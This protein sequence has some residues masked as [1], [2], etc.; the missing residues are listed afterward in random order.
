[1]TLLNEKTP[2]AQIVLDHSEC[3]GVFQR[4]RIDYCCKGELP[5]DEACRQRGADPKAV[6]EELERAVAERREPAGIDPREVPTDVLVS[7]IVRRHHQYLRDALPFL[8][9]L[10]KKVARVHGAHNPNLPEVRD[11]VEELSNLML[12]HLDREE[13]VLFPALEGEGKGREEVIAAELSTMHGDHLEVA[14]VLESLRTAASEFEIPDWACTS[15]TTLYRE[16][17]AVEADIFQ[18][19]HLENHVLMPRFARG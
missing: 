13:Q 2:V 7:H 12:P 3:A 5:L 18:H 1:M 9:P 16:L 10:S 6:L 19:V 17:A 4:H 11:L 15:Y 8:V 14:K